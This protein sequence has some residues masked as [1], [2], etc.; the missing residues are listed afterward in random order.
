MLLVAG[1][2]VRSAPVRLELASDFRGVEPGLLA[3]YQV[4][5][6]VEH[7]Q[8]PEA[9]GRT[10]AV[11]PAAVDEQ[12]LMAVLEGGPF[13]RLLRRGSAR[14]CDWRTGRGARG[15]RRLFRS[16]SVPPLIL[17]DCIGC[18]RWGSGFTARW[19]K[20]YCPTG[21]GLASDADRYTSTYGP[22]YPQRPTPFT[23]IPRLQARR[24]IGLP[25]PSARVGGD[26]GPAAAVRPGVVWLTQ[27][28]RA[29]RTHRATGRSRAYAGT[30]API[31]GVRCSCGAVG[32]RSGRF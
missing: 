21:R 24:I 26:R 32:C 17:A 9:D 22:V 27:A 13:D 14:A 31:A 7:V 6:D 5:A 18:L 23:A 1:W 25:W 15:D 28:A 20:P 29:T 19:G 4:V 30:A 16:S 10:A 2:L 8:H 11:E 12:R 3:T